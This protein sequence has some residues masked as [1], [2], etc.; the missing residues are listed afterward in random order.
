MKGNYSVWLYQS[1]ITYPNFT[2]EPPWVSGMAQGL[3]V[4]VLAHAY[5][6]T[7]D[8]KYLKAARLALNSF[9]VPVEGVEYFTSMKMVDGGIWSMDTEDNLNQELSTDSCML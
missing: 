8:E 1:R 9:F 6:L 3:G 4:E 2:L 7:G 5:N